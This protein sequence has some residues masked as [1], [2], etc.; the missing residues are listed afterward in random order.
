MHKCFPMTRF[1][2]LAALL[3]LI[4]CSRASGAPDAS[5]ASQGIRGKR[6]LIVYFSR[7]ENTQALAEIIHQ[8][9]GGDMLQLELVTPYP[10]DYRATVRQVQREN[11]TSY[12]PPL[13]TRIE[14]LQHY[15]TVFVGFPTWDMQLPPPMKSFLHAYDLSG[16]TVIPFNTNA[17]YGKGSSFQTVRKL[18]PR[19][20]ILE[21]F[22][23]EGGR[24]RDG[25]L[26]AIKGT[27]RDEVRD[28][29]AGWLKHIGIMGR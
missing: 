8:Q 29:V 7:T 21:G 3:S 2:C 24:E 20:K 12:L 28:Q 22:A 5:A 15:D 6:V 9:V 16:K 1:F 18:C 14:N 25:I 19:S 10:R 23:I 27:R 26:L 13:K 17:G 11:E 4:A